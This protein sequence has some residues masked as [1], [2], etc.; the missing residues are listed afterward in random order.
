[1]SSSN[2]DENEVDTSK[3]SIDLGEEHGKNERVKH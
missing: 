1:M 3:E 2:D